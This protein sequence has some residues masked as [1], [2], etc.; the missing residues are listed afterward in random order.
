MQNPAPLPSDLTGTDEAKDRKT[1]C[2]ILEVFDFVTKTGQ[3]M[4][5]L[6]SSKEPQTAC[7]PTKRRFVAWRSQSRLAKNW[8]ESSA[9]P[10]FVN[11]AIEILLYVGT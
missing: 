3:T 2:E 1:A 4:I 7:Q 5:E 8:S 9:I 11:I 6:P 10:V